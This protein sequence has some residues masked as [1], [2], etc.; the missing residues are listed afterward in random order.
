MVVVNVAHAE[1]EHN[2][3]DREQNK[4]GGIL[5]NSLMGFIP[6]WKRVTGSD[7]ILTSKVHMSKGGKLGHKG[8]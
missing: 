1:R 6:S 8:T 5:G 7:S 4:N 2:L 3:V